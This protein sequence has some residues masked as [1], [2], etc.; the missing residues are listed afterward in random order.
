M[1]GLGTPYLPGLMCYLAT[2]ANM[3]DAASMCGY[4][5]NQAPY[6]S[7]GSGTSTCQSSSSAAHAVS[8]TSSQSSSL[9]SSTRSPS[10][11]SSSLTTAA[12]TAHGSLC[13]LSYGLPST[14]DYP[15][16][17]AT[18]LSFVYD[19]TVVAGSVRGS[20][21]VRLLNGT[22]SRTFTNRFGT[23]FTTTFTLSTSGQSSQANLLYL[24]ST[25]PVD[26]TGLTW[27]M[28]SPVQLPGA[29]PV[30][31][32]SSLQVYNASGAVVEGGW[33]ELVDPLGQSFL[34]SIPSFV[35][36][37][38]A[39]SNVNTL[40]AVYSQCQAPIT[41]TNGLRQPTQP[42]VS[43][44]ATHIS[45]SYFISD[46][47]TYSVQTNLTI[48][49][50]SAFANTNDAIGSPYQTI[51]AV[52]GTRLYTYLP[53][54]TTQLSNITGL[55]TSATSPPSQR[56]YPYALLSAAPGVYSVNTAPFIDGNGIGFSVFP[57][58]PANGAPIGVNGAG[59][60]VTKLQL[61]ALTVGASAVLTDAP[62]S[63]NAPLISTQLQSYA[64]M[65]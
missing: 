20:A 7:F 56:F 65:Q 49:T 17:S 8:R 35:N 13:L 23:S 25:W 57:A 5:V 62:Y 59:Y 54:L 44:G 43:N 50:T 34:S 28:T 64:L 11:T 29:G 63:T 48:T 3:S 15:W 2:T 36:S 60:S 38:I 41:F 39:A 53:T 4:A 10:I 37:T 1:T 24:N 12:P 51:I 18:L 14:I 46:G 30:S 52:T 42:S 26:S 21:A 47:T 32:Y 19:P 16:S 40:A 31:L 27:L 58:I 33:G 45:Y 55:S 9:S 61:T 6:A 22:G